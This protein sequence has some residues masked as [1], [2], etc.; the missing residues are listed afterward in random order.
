MDT[1]NGIQSHV[2][3]SS[4]VGLGGNQFE[5][6]VINVPANGTIA[7]GTV[8]VREGSHFVPATEIETFVEVES[9]SETVTISATKTVV[10]NPFDI[11]NN[12]DTAAD[13]S[14][15]V[16]ISG[17]VRADFLKIG[18]RNTTD[19]ENDVIRGSTIVPI[20]VNDISRTE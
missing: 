11:Q 7:K 8:L 6:G 10:I 5:T 4:E 19:A 1:R 14:L 17:P 2:V 9:G 18:G 13:M 16:I 3:D 20:K 12:K 15:R